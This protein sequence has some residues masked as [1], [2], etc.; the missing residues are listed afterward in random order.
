MSDEELGD[1]IEKYR[2]MPVFHRRTKSVSWMGRKG[3]GAT[4]MTGDGVNDAPARKRQISVW[5]WDYR[6]GS[7][8]GCRIHDPDR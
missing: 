2:F 3:A 4:A 5:R 1:K 6:Y 7:I 8:Q